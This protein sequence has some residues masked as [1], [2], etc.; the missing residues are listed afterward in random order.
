MIEVWHHDGVS[1]LR[2]DTEL[3]P[4]G[5]GFRLRTAPDTVIAWADLMPGDD[6]G[7]GPF[8]RH[9][10]LPGWRLGFD[11]PPPAAIAAKLPRAARYGGLIDRFGLAPSV[12]AFAAAS[13]VVLAM[14]LSAPYYIAPLIPASFEQQLGDAMVG[15][16]GGRICDGDGGQAALDRLVARIEPAPDGLKVRVINV[17][18]V[19]AVA[20]PG[21][22]IFLFKGL[23]Q[24]AQSPDEVAGVVGHEI[25]HV[26]NRDVMQALLRQTGL[27]L[28]LGGVGGN[29]GGYLNAMVSATY[30]RS[31]ETR[32]DGYAIDALRRGQIT[33]EATAGFFARLAASEASLGRAAAALGYLS[34]HPMSQS[35]AQAFRASRVAGAGYASA[36]SPA[37]WRALVDICRNDPDVAKDS[38]L[39]F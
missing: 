27:S 30:S 38:G 11:E 3:T 26:R 25:G 29:S 31:A 7:G 22:N 4:V 14:V 32:A 10:T 37:E 16:M 28:V 21:G 33:P 1:A 15:D 17:D 36:L 24:A 19:N 6:R 20:L 5:D 23:L 12:A 13:A 39:F 2:H 34:S 35:R 9:R 18:M 8:Y